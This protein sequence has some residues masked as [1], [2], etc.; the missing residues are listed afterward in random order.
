MYVLFFDICFLQLFI[1][2][3][4]YTY[5]RASN[6]MQI[7]YCA[8][9]Y[10]LASGLYALYYGGDILVG[11]LWV[12]ELGAGLIF[13]IFILHFTTF[14]YTHLPF[15]SLYLLVSILGM[16]YFFFMSTRMLPE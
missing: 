8:G 12:I 2:F 5:L 3:T 15:L 10:L 7:W 13:F 16:F 6:I 1:L 4:L 11:F 14:L 9:L